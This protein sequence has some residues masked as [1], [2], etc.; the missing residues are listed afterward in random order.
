MAHLGGTDGRGDLG[1]LDELAAGGRMLLAALRALVTDYPTDGPGLPPTVRMTLTGP[2]Q[3]LGEVDVQAGHL[4]WIAGLLHDEFETCR[5]A[6]HDQ[7]GQCAHCD[8]SGR[9]AGHGPS[10]R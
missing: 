7:S 10:A 4:A 1:N 5:N 8:G 2:D 9:A 6:H 3:H